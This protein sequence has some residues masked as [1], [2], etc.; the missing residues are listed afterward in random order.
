VATPDPFKLAA[1]LEPLERELTDGFQ[2]PKPVLALT[3]KAL[4]DQ[5]GE[6]V[7][8]CIADPFGSTE[9]KAARE[10]GESGEKPLLAL[11]E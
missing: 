3:D 8:I 1:L 9:R 7:E 5:G 6:R 2:H 4:L 10:N 11:V